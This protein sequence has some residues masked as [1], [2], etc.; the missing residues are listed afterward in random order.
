MA[1]ASWKACRDTW[2]WSWTGLVWVGMSWEVN[3][4]RRQ[5][6]Q[7]QLCEVMRQVGQS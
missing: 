3:E 2:C 5:C 4:S 1:S 6:S 7:D